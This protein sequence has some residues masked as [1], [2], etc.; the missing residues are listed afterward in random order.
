MHVLSVDL[1]SVHMSSLQ[2]LLNK[3]AQGQRHNTL[4]AKAK[5]FE[6]D[7]PSHGNVHFPLPLSAGRE[8]ADQPRSA[9][10]NSVPAISA[11]SVRR[12]VRAL[13]RRNGG[14]WMPIRTC[15]CDMVLGS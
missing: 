4:R 12:I 2:A 13:L 6:E 14:G 1:H 9:A 7:W 3:I 11:A 8:A 10:N 5:P 15:A